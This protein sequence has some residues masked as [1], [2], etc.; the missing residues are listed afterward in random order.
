MCKRAG[1]LENRAV[2]VVASPDSAARITLC[3]GMTLPVSTSYVEAKTTR[4]RCSPGP[5]RRH[6]HGWAG[7]GICMLAVVMADSDA[8]TA[9][10]LMDEIA[11]EHRRQQ[12]SE[13]L[14]EL[15]RSPEIPDCTVLLPL[16]NHRWWQ[17]R[18]EA[19][20]ALGKCQADPRA[21]TALI[22]VLATTSDDYDRIYANVALGECGTAAA[23]P[24]LA[25]EIHHPTDD[26]KCSA[27]Y[28]L[29]QIGDSSLLPVFLDALTDRSAAAK[30]YAMTAI[31]RHGNEQAIGPICDRVH[32]ILRRKRKHKQLPES[33]LLRALKFL[34]QHQGDE[35]ARKTLTWAAEKRT[36]YLTD[37]EARWVRDNVPGPRP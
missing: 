4:S 2:S 25:A 6:A 14:A 16:V 18:H 26:V 9:R 1:T 27:I 23:I 20:L 22:G 29:E 34:A 5:G 33:E 10:D 19:M 37:D 32:V 11:S 13:L 35:V 15:R 17:V 3:R 21:Q 12:L 36:A 7:H 8:A 28:A 24:A 30:W 31:S